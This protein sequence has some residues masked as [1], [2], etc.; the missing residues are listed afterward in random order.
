MRVRKHTIDNLEIIEFNASA[1]GGW[2]IFLHGGP[3]MLGYMETFCERFSSH[4]KAVYYEQRGSKQGD[5]DIGVL[6]H[7]RDLER[8][9]GCYSEESKPIIVGHSWGAMLAV[10][11]AGRY[12]K[13]LQKVILTGCGPLNKHQENEFQNELNVRFGDRK[14]YYDSLWNAIDE[15]K[16]EDKQQKLADHYI[17]KMAE[18]Y[19]KD[20]RSSSEAQPSH[21]DYKGSY[22]TMCESEEYVSNN[23]YVKAL[24]EIESRLTVIH[25]SYDII[26][27]KSHFSLIGKHVPHAKTIMLEKAGHCPWSGR[28]REEFIETLKQE[29][30]EHTKPPPPDEVLR[31]Q[32]W[33]ETR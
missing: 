8:I 13:S 30:K 15:E 18:I 1:H 12:P 2:V 19:Q 3:G 28:C 29:V 26:S 21:W 24:S 27:P 7:L 33:R 14:D 10:L 25:G 31:K 17:D 9:V 22:R 23:L 11:F 6:D 4:C 32:G 20:P 5:D 16:D